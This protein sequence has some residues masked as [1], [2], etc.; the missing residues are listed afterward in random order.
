MHNRGYALPLLFKKLRRHLCLYPETYGD[1]TFH[2]LLRDVSLCFQFLLSRFGAAHQ[3]QWEHHNVA[4]PSSG[5]T[6]GDMYGAPIDWNAAQ[7]ES[8]EDEL[9]EVD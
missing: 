6:L 3:A 5:S 1:Y 2:P 7:V 8:D 4:W 9:M